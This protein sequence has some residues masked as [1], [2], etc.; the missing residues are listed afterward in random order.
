M[1]RYDNRVT[2]SDKA[3]KASATSGD[4]HQSGELR[5]MLRALEQLGYDLDALLAASGLRREDVEDP[6]GYISGRACSMLFARASEEGL[7]PNLALHLA[8]HTPIGSN[9]LL[10]YLIV[11]SATVEQGLDRLARYLRVV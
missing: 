10:D 5:G 4:S 11:S 2:Q 6:N 9:P 1:T 3:E 7:V 8:I